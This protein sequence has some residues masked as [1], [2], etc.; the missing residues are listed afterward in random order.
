MMPY[1]SLLRFLV[2]K[3]SYADDLR[4]EVFC[5]IA[6]LNII[7]I[8]ISIFWRHALEDSQSILH[9]VVEISA[10]KVVKGFDSVIKDSNVIDGS[11]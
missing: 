11:T 8:F 10:Y 6:I 5:P 3:I 1:A 7:I 4:L 2:E 9:V